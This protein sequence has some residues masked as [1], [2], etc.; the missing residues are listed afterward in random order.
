MSTDYYSS[1]KLRTYFKE[2]SS[3]EL[4]QLT[5][6]VDEYSEK[7]FSAEKLQKEAC[8]AAGHSFGNMI[9]GEGVPYLELIQNACEYWG[10]KDVP[11]MYDK[12][13]G[14]TYAKLDWSTQKISVTQAKRHSLV[15]ERLA[16]LERL[17]VG[18][19][20]GDLYD[21]M[22]PDQKAD[23]AREMSLSAGGTKRGNALAALAPAATIAAAKA[24]GFGTY[25]LMSTVL[26]T[27]SMGTLGF[28]SYML[29]SRAL[30]VL[31]GPAGLIAAGALGL[32]Q[33]GS[34]SKEKV[35]KIGLCCALISMRIQH[36]SAELE[37]A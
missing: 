27:A 6:I 37:A 8:S 31:L 30:S 24:G 25:M 3:D 14:E 9:R 21:K 29:A 5:K 20:A 28:G 19:V 11:S 12:A 32:I 2:A 10:V 26:K 17:L 22:T 33:L 13:E 36:E 23:V 34:P 15:D 16:K 7:P 35:A 4:E 18:K 1:S